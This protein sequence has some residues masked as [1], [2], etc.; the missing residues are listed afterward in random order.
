MCP[1]YVCTV[2]MAETE[3]H[4]EG[5]VLGELERL[6]TGERGVNVIEVERLEVPL[7]HARE[8]RV[9]HGHLPHL[10]H[11][12]GRVDLRSHA[13]LAKGVGQPLLKKNPIKNGIMS[14]STHTARTRQ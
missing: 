14:S 4:R 8:V 12:K 13:Q 11:R 3:A 5:E 6:E 9:V 2:L 1:A 10:P 7:V